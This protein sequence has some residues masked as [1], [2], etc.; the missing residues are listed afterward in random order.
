MQEKDE[1]SKSYTEMSKKL[2]KSHIL[3]GY[4]E[5]YGGKEGICRFNEMKINCKKY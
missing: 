1:I 2:K 4:K 5:K 3:D